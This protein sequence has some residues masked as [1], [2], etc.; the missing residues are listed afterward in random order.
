M[1]VLIKIN[2][3]GGLFFFHFNRI[4]LV[5]VYR[6]CNQ[7]AQGIF[8]SLLLYVALCYFLKIKLKFCC[9]T[10]FCSEILS[11]LR[12]GSLFIY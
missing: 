1:D 12:P 3:C 8:M 7:L 11:I 9:Y 2:I 4:L 10:Y 6:H 5:L